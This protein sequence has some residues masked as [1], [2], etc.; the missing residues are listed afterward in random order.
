MAQAPVWLGRFRDEPCRC[1]QSC[2]VKDHG[3]SYA[4]PVPAG[5]PRRP[6]Q[7]REC[8]GDTWPKALGLLKQAGL[9]WVS[10]VR[11]D[12]RPHVTPVVAVW[13]DGALYFSSGPGEQKSRNL[14]ANRQCAVTTGWVSSPRYSRN[15]VRPLDKHKSI[16]LFTRAAKITLLTRRSSRPS[17]CT[18][19]PIGMPICV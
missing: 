17:V 13:M 15:R 5:H 3:R 18:Q 6:L 4:G 19:S 9:F 16:D 12:G 2:A 1:W 11:P 7:R 10:T 14:A 8:P